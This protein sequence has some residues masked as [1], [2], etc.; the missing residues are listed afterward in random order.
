MTMA[1]DAKFDRRQMVTLLVLCAAPFLGVVDTT[2]V[3]IAL[4]SMST[5]LGLSATDAQWVLNGYALVYG[6]LLLLLGRMGDLW[7]RRRLFLLGLVLFAAASLLGGFAPVP[8][9]LI[10]ARVA[11]GVGAA[12]FTPAALSLVATVFA[13]GEARNRALGI[14]GAMAAVGF[15]V[16]MVLGGVITE[17]LGWRWIFYLNVPIAAAVLLVAPATLPESRSREVVRSLDVAGAVAVTLAIGATIYAVSGIPEYG[18]SGRTLGIGLFG[19]GAAVGFVLIERR[20][21]APLVPLPLLRAR[22]MAAPNGLKILISTIGTAW[23]YVLTFYFQDVRS[24]SPLPTGLLFLPMTIA[25]IVGAWAG[26]RLVTAVGGKVVVLVGTALIGGGL[27]LMSTLPVTGQLAGVVAGMVVGELGFMMAIVPLAI[28]ITAA[29]HADQRG[30]AA[31]LL[32]TSDQLGNALGLSITVSVAAVVTA[33]LAQGVPTLAD[34]LAGLR[35][36]LWVSIVVAAL[37]WVMALVALRREDFRST[38]EHA[39]HAE[40]PGEAGTEVASAPQTAD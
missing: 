3:T 15:V 17:L 26:G 20:A 37:T 14:W 11:Q 28:A 39:E 22:R 9:V 36:G 32:G 25:S 40:H 1:G 6:G 8:W 21:P 12:A 33:R 4:P 2:I 35:A 7:G 23:L 30:L 24:L 16:G 13:E 34:Y 31:G 5:A 18:W 38:A 27:L 19:V 10:V 29:A